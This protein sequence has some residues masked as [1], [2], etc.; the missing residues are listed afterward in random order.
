MCWGKPHA[1]GEMDLKAKLWLSFSREAK[2]PDK[3]QDSCFF[4]SWMRPLI[5]SLA[6]GHA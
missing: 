4:H 2:D 6:F 5:H 3:F 1:W